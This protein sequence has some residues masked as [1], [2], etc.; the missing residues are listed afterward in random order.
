MRVRDGSVVGNQSA[1]PDDQ[2]DTYKAGIE[3]ASPRK[4]SVRR[5]GIG[6]AAP[7]EQLAF[8]SEYDRERSYTDDNAQ[9]LQLRH[10][11]HEDTTSGGRQIILRSRNSFCEWNQCREYHVEGRHLPD[12]PVK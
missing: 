3:K 8:F 5:P 9:G 1:M 7:E 11:G 12:Y 10:I 4:T 2:T 6:E